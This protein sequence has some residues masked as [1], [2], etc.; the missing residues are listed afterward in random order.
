MGPAILSAWSEKPGFAV[1]LLLAFY[2]TMISTSMV[3]IY[4][5]GQAMLLG[6]GARRWLSL[7][8]ALLLVGLGSYFLFQAGGNLLGLGS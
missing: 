3:I 2:L 7:I 4:L 1:A 8:S 6:E 5:M